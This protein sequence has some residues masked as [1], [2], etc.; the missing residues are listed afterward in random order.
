M[1]VANTLAYSKKY[2]FDKKLMSFNPLAKL[3]TL[4]FL[5]NYKWAQ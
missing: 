3:T 1:I 4:Q 2:K 5:H